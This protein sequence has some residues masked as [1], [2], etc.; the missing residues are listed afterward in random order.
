M[1]VVSTQMGHHHAAIILHTIP[2]PYLTLSLYIAVSIPVA[3]GEFVLK[4]KKYIHKR[5]KAYQV[6]KIEINSVAISVE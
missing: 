6:T 4:M 5:F 1:N 2:N 3:A